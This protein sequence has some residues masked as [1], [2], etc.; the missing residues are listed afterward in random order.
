MKKFFIGFI[1]FVIGSSA[2]WLLSR[3]A[4]LSVKNWDGKFESIFRNNLHRLGL[5]DHDL[6]SSVHQIKKDRRGEWI[7]HQASLSLKD[8]EKKDELINEFKRAGA[9]VSEKRVG[10]ISTLV[11]KKGS[12]VYQEIKLLPH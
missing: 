2:W 12:R 3:T 4:S 6:V 5:S 8:S 1:F 10:D 7:F 11:V 9:E